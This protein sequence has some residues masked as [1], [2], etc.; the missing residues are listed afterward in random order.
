[1]APIQMVAM[2]LRVVLAGAPS[3]IP[4]VVGSLLCPKPQA[5][6]AGFSPATRRHE[7]ERLTPIMLSEVE[8]HGHGQRL[9]LRTLR[10][11]DA[12]VAPQQEAVS[13]SLGRK[14]VVAL[15]S[16]CVVA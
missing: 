16:T 10:M 13:A 11:A 15:P 5:G 1:M 6:V 3:I 12:F 14:S 7:R 8:V 4:S 2:V 9:H